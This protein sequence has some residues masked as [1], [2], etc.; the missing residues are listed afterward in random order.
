MVR[1]A[2]ANPL[3]PPLLSWMQ[4][5]SDAARLRLL[6]LIERQELGV[7]ELC[8]VLQ[9]PQSTVSRHLKMLTDLGWA[10][11]RRNGTANLYRM[12]LDELEPPARKLWLLARQQMDQ[13]PSA[14]QDQL[15]LTR[16]LRQRRSE[17]QSFFAT[18]AGKWDKLRSELYGTSF[19]DAALHALLPADW[20]IADLG[21]GTGVIAAQLAPYVGRVIGVDQS[22]AMLKT[23]ARR[24]AEHDNVELRR[25][26]LEA[27]P[28]DDG[29]ADAAILSIVL[30]YVDN[31]V[32]VLTESARVVRPGGR[33]VVVDLL[34]H[35][36]DDFRRQ[37]GQHRPGFDTDEMEAM[38]SDADLVG[39]RCRPLP[40]DRGAKGPALIL[41]TA[42]RPDN[43]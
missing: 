18:T 15:R 4:S 31:P 1:T 28:L 5:L 17:A 36:R 34:R 40:P 33:I 26:D 16:R 3:Q 2:H 37:M 12:T 8:D 7:A 38:L 11:C 14:K 10:A 35:E 21:C 30:T 24:A 20:T 41:A 29:E 22:Q 25:G 27:L 23:A 32:A 42:T 43:H 6:R 39:T 19:S 13:T 9:M